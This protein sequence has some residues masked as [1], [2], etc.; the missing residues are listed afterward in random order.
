MLSFF[1]KYSFRHFLLLFIFTLLFSIH[2]FPQMKGIY[3]VGKSSSDSFQSIQEAVDSIISQGISGNTIIKIKGGSY[4]EQIIIKWYSGA[5]L[6]SLTFEPYD[7]SPVLIWYSPALTNS[8][9]II[10]IDSAGNINFNQ[11]NFK[12]S[13]QNAGRI[14]ELYG[15]CTRISFEKNTFYGVKTNATSDNFAIIYG[16][17][18][19]CDSFFI[20]SNIFYDGSTAIL[21]NGPTVPSAGNRI[22]NNLFLNQYASAIE[23]ENQNG[24]IITGNII[25]TNS[26]HTQFIG[27]ELSASSGP[28]QIS[29]NKISHNTNGFSILL[30]KV[31]SSKGNET[32]VTNN[33]TAPGGNAAAIGIFIETCSFIN[34][35]HNNIHIS[36]TTLG[37]AGR[38]INIQ[39]SSGYCGNIN[40]F[41]N[42]MV[43][44]GPG[45]GLIT[46]TTDTIS[47]NYNCYYTSGYIGY[48]N[49]YLSNTLS[50]WSLYSKQDT[51]SM[52]A[53]PLF[54]SNTDL[55]IREKQLA[56]KGKYFSEVATDIDGEIRDTGR[57]TIGADELI[58]YNRDLAVL[59]FSPAALLCPGDSA[60]V[61]IKI[62]NAGTDTAFNFI[63]RLY[64]DNQL[65]DSIYHITNLVPDAET[66][67]SGGMVFMPLNK[68]V[69]VS[70]NVLFA[71]GLT[72]QNYKN[73]SM[74]K[75]L[76][77]AFKDTL[78]I[79]KQGKGNYL[80]I[81]EAF[82]DI[83][84]RGI[85]N[86]LTLLIKPG[87]YTE[88]LNLDSIPGLYYP[89][90]LN[91][92]GLKSN[93]DSVVVRFG[94][95]NWYANYV[96]RIGISNL[97]IQ[98]INFIADGNVYGKIIELSGT[99]A[100]L[101][102]DSNAFYGQKV[103]NTSTEFAL[104]SMSGDNFRDTNLVF[105]N[106]YFSDGSYGI[107]LAGKD[108]ISYN[109]NC[110]FFNN[111]FT[112]Q[113]GYG[114]YCLY[115]RNLDIQQNIINNNVSAS[116]YAGIYTYYCS[117]IRQIGRNRI[118]LNSGSSGI[119]LIASPGITTDKSL[120]SNN[121][122]DM[123][124]KETNARCLMLDNSSN[125]NVYHNTFR[126][127]N[128]Y[129]AGTVLDMTSSTS[130]IDIKNNIFVNT[131]GSMVINAAG[132]N[133]IT[134]NFNIL[135]TIGSNFGNWNGLRTSFTDWV[136]ASNQDKQSK[137]LSPLFKDTKD[138]HC[139]DIAC[140][141]A[142]TPLPAVKTD[143]DGDSRNSLYPDIGADE[144][145]LKNSDVSL[146]GFPSFSSPS[147]D[148][149][150]K[151]SVSLQ[152]RGK[153][154]LDSIMIYWKINQNQF[155]SKYYF[156]KLKYFQTIN[157]LLGTYH[158]SADSN[159]SIEVKAGWPNGKADEDSSNNIIV[160]THLNL[161]PT[162]GQLQ[163]TEDTVCPGYSA[164]LKA[165]SP[166]A[167]Y[168]YW[169]ENQNVGKVIGFDSLFKTPLLEKSMTYYVVAGSKMK[170]DSLKIPFTTSLSNLTNGNMFDVITN[171]KSIWI[172]SFEVHTQYKNTYT[173]L[174][175][176]KN[177]SS[178]G[179]QNDSLS[180]TRHDSITVQASG[181]GKP[182]RIPLSTPIYIGHED[183]YSIYITTYQ[184]SFVN[185]T[186]GSGTVN[187]ADFSI[188]NGIALDYLFEA[189]YATPAVWNG[190]V[191][192][193]TG[194]YCSTL[195]AAVRAL[196][197]DK[198]QAK[199]P[200]DTSL[201]SG[202]TLF[203]DGGDDLSARYQWSVLPSNQ[204]ISSYDTITIYKTG[205][206]RLTVEDI[207]GNK[208]ID[209]IKVSAA[210]SPEADFSIDKPEQ[211]LKDNKFLFTNKSFSLLD[212][213][214]F[215]WD[216]GDSQYSF[217]RDAGYSYSKT[218][219]YAVVLT[220][221]TTKGCID[222]ALRYIEVFPS[223][224]A[225][226]EMSG[227]QFCLYPHQVTFLN[228]SVIDSGTL[229]YYW[230]F[231]DN[232]Q[233]QLFEP[234]YTYSKAGSY[235]IRLTVSSENNC[236][237]SFSDSV[238]IKPNPVVN[239]GNDTVICAGKRI[240]L[241]AGFGFDSYLWSN[242]SIDPV[243]LVDSSGT[244]IGTKVVWV[245]VTHHGCETTDSI[246]ITFKN[247]TGI[248]EISYLKPS[249]YPNPGQQE[250]WISFPENSPTSSYKIKFYDLSGK[251]LM[252]HSSDEKR[253]K[254]DTGNLSPGSYLIQID[255][256]TGLWKYLWIKQ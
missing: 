183:T 40:I 96:F 115:F 149:Q 76:W 6:Y 246:L 81:G 162:P 205:T 176:T 17:G 209:T 163:I 51:N 55:H 179:Y 147:C 111:I 239:L 220:A 247:C 14:I 143:I 12:N 243:I 109:N 238:V 237:D 19:I 231:G 90:K 95:V 166:N 157:L 61:H 129:Y 136:T 218:G 101:I 92:I 114:L 30:N 98:N 106:N 207:C 222:T 31:N 82:S 116:Y 2:A 16:S 110:L 229:H 167:R 119:Y 11:L 60:P 91:I 99:N 188:T 169:Y 13:S 9:Y 198:I 36:S 182:T 20:D 235:I 77:P 189:Q 181:F 230:D 63:T 245:R 165:Y 219:K 212:S 204:N 80:S 132:T 21:I 32:W 124:G 22:S 161:L 100:N 215:K 255:D 86:N 102:F 118:F 45:F 137:N 174:I 67:I 5:Q 85:C 196:V 64:I 41:N 177:G 256:G 47:A 72:D 248:E 120:I 89:K 160:T 117:N 94:A 254:I 44:R 112:N 73:N 103:T 172:D 15:D 199:L 138:L 140:D 58:L 123:Y 195:P 236:R 210:V 153:S 250:L 142:G 4:N 145:I 211:C 70:V 104:I 3:T 125:F 214:T 56:G 146:N 57:C 23:S 190:N 152:N 59:Q 217:L 26:F 75:S 131:G 158:F 78:I 69:K 66:D 159:Y 37:S 234:V 228:K 128:Q 186:P 54:Y 24:I 79:D 49:G 139:Q 1:S 232:G 155:S 193:S 35:F 108:N 127:G 144:F 27:I 185:F 240:L 202:N 225:K 154:P 208:S 34:V 171:T 113:Y 170:P 105:R 191:F 241:N 150:H 233:S 83:Q 221:I 253:F 242:D 33:F 52:V 87:V 68:P 173:F 97:S 194:S 134:S 28:N 156:N 151:L 187:G 130:G 74:E 48:W 38:C 107:Y 88:Q 252:T 39:N 53:N 29:A 216:F 8:N 141:S 7:T 178:S 10:R 184:V 50:I 223:P 122:I 251:W 133:N 224:Q 213:M 84:S 227:H 42:I 164:Q 244:G 201:C 168:Y 203:L 65:T 200:D 18:N 93:Q 197:R 180:W 175:Y 148:G 71:G 43:N 206:Y 46:F 62:K 135:Y 192:Y 25:Q 121:F 226:F 126:Q 249:V